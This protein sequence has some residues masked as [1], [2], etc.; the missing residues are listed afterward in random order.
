MSPVK[1]WSI[2]LE[3]HTALCI[4]QHSSWIVKPFGRASALLPG[5]GSGKG[6]YCQTG[7]HS[8]SLEWEHRWVNLHRSS[9]WLEMAVRP[10]AAQIN[11]MAGIQVAV[12]PGC[13]AACT[14]S[15]AAICQSQ[16]VRQLLRP[17]A[18]LCSSAKGVTSHPP[19][20]LSPIHSQ[21]G[22]YIEQEGWEDEAGVKKKEVKGNGKWTRSIHHK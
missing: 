10:M 4:I 12:C 9:A 1:C 15:R 14:G 20:T 16:T 6:G 11:W 3:R 21:L 17:G 5:R 13:V 18:N 7:L 22:E 19:L 2:K 8:T